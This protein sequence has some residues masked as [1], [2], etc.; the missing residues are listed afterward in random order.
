MEVA[1]DVQTDAPETA[2]T[3]TVSEVFEDGRVLNIRDDIKTYRP[4]STPDNAALV[5]DL[6]PIDWTLSP[7]SRLRLD[8]SSSNFPAFPAHPNKT[9]IWS[10]VATTATARQTLYGGSIRLPTTRR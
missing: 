8:I 2:F 1:L 7:G 6:V 4:A 3:V 10:A 9:G 5:F